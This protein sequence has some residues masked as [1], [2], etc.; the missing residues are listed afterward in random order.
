[1]D[2]HFWRKKWGE[3]EANVLP[4]V[5]KSFLVD[6]GTRCQM[7][8]ANRL[9]I[10]KYFYVICALISKEITQY[11][12]NP[13]EEFV[14]FGF[15]FVE[16]AITSFIANENLPEFQGSQDEELEMAIEMQT[17]VNLLQ[18]F[19]LDEGNFDVNSLGVDIAALELAYNLAVQ[20]IP[21]ETQNDQKPVPIIAENEDLREFI[22]N[23]KNSG[24][25]GVWHQINEDGSVSV[26]DMDSKKNN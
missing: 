11:A 8:F 25:I 13:E 17:L 21:K 22:Q 12:V 2:Q 16:E 14:N 18:S 24:N 20:S 23:L 5:L 10:A 15:G 6:E 26:F 19:T 9:L 7:S 4:Y 1:M 3:F